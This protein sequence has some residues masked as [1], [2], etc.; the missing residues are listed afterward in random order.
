MHSKIELIHF[1]VWC[2]IF[3]FC[4]HSNGNIINPF[5]FLFP[6]AFEVNKCRKPRYL[7]NDGDVHDAGSDEYIEDAAEG[8]FRSAI[9]NRK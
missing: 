3:F 6:H 9:P 8:E 7:I 1:G 4:L 2:I 5:S